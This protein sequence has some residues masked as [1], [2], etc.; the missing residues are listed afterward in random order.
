MRCMSKIS[1][2]VL[3]SRSDKKDKKDKKKDKKEHDEH[4]HKHEKK[5]SRDETHKKDDE[6]KEDKNKGTLARFFVVNGLMAV[7]GISPR[8][9]PP[10]GLGARMASMF[11]P[12]KEGGHAE[13][14]KPE[15]HEDKKEPVR[16]HRSLIG[17]GSLETP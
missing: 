4:K 12:R 9:P 17:H 3:T 2:H 6:H 14:A 11:S 16:T 1:P 8:H 15:K 5:D 7:G 13:P 10:Q